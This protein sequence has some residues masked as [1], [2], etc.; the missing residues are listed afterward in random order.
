MSTTPAKALLN[1]LQNW[2]AQFIAEQ[3]HLTMMDIHELRTV[4][5]RLAEAIDRLATGPSTM[6]QTLPDQT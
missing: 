6:P 4:I 5:S 3:G 2:E 1:D